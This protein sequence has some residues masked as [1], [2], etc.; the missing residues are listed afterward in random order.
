MIRSRK[1]SSDSYK[2]NNELNE[3]ETVVTFDGCGNNEKLIEPPRSF[4]SQ[5]HQRLMAWKTGGYDSERFRNGL[6][7]KSQYSDKT[8]LK[9]KAVLKSAIL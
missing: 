2:L 7:M 1:Q 3:T 4:R 5:S 9:S 6:K 8:E